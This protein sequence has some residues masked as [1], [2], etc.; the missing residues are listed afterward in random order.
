MPKVFTNTDLERMYFKA[1]QRYVPVNCMWML[2][3]LALELLNNLDVG[4]YIDEHNN[5]NFD[6]FMLP[7]TDTRKLYE[8]PTLLKEEDDES[9]PNF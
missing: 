7:G 9:H 5:M 2:R 4:G 6:E 1:T 3:A 8:L